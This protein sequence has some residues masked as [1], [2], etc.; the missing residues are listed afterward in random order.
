MNVLTATAPRLGISELISEATTELDLRACDRDGVFQ[1][2]IGKITDLARK[3]EARQALLRSV[4]EREKLCTTGLGHGLALPHT[5]NTIAGLKHATIVF[6][7]HLHG[8]PYDAPDGAP[9]KL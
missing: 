7:R 4:Q 3:A 2:L 8:I 6:G 5:R 1:E 9:V